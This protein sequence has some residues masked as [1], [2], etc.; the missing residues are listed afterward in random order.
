MIT[1]PQQII[2]SLSSAPRWVNSSVILNKLCCKVVD[3]AKTN[4]ALSLCLLGAMKNAITV[5]VSVGR[6]GFD[7]RSC[8]SHRV[9]GVSCAHTWRG[10]VPVHFPTICPLLSADLNVFFVIV[11][12]YK[13]GVIQ[14]D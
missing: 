8:R 9:Q 3:A 1:R 2:C 6:F 12:G 13:T 7:C 10:L 5:S 4:L 11:L 14:C